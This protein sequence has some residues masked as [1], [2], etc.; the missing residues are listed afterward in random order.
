MTKNKKTIDVTPENSATKSS[1]TPMVVS[2]LLLAALAGGGYF[3]WQQ[4]LLT[5]PQTVEI[6]NPEGA[7]IT[8]IAEPIM[9]DDAA[10]T[11]A[12]KL[13]LEDLY[14]THVS[15]LQALRRTA[16]SAQANEQRTAMLVDALNSMRTVINDMDMKI[17]KL[18]Q[19]PAVAVTGIVAA[20]DYSAVFGNVLADTK[21]MLYKHPEK[22]AA[23]IALL[24]KIAATMNNP[25]LVAAVEQLGQTAKQQPVIEK[26][27]VEPTTAP[28]W[29]R[30]ITVNK[31]AVKNDFKKSAAHAALHHVKQV[32]FNHLEAMLAEA[33]K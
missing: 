18:E 32:Y 27:M 23:K 33:Q 28:W 19:A 10:A 1:A 21:H 5:A 30:F 26:P 11:P 9:A 12:P 17:N 6:A 29:S 4:G 7:T 24:G 14:Q 15:T 31:A 2:V 13:T 25:E 16:E 8:P 20:P 22:A 3:A